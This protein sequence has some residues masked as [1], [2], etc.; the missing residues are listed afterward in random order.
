MLG[1]KNNY[2]SNGNAYLKPLYILYIFRSLNFFVYLFIHLFIYSY[3]FPA[4]LSYDNL[5]H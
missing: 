5:F 1:R 2:Q 4:Y 3:N